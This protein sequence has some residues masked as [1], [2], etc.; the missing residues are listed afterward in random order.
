MSTLFF[1]LLE[2]LL[3][4]GEA[5]AFNDADGLLLADEVSVRFARI[6]DLE[7]EGY[8]A[9]NSL[10]GNLA[11]IRKFIHMRPFR[12]HGRPYLPVLS[13]KYDFERNETR[14]RLTLFM[15][16]DDLELRAVG[17]RFEP[18]EGDAYGEDEDGETEAGTHDFFHVQPITHLEVGRADL[19]IPALPALSVGQPS[20]PLDARDYIELFVCLVITVYGRR[21]ASTVEGVHNL[22]AG[23]LAGMRT[24]ATN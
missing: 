21:Y 3:D 23:R 8:V 7:L 6:S 9:D 18:P 15:L 4:Q 11:D 19:A 2:W 12:E 14:L 13:V 24:F 20:F 16:D 17:F 1:G 10:R 22:M 5:A